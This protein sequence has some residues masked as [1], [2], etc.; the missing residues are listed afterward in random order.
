MVLRGCLREILIDRIEEIVSVGACSGVVGVP[1]SAQADAKTYGVTAGGGR[2]IIL[3][4]KDVLMIAGHTGVAAPGGESS[5]HGYGR[6]E[7]GGDLAVAHA[8]PLEVG[9]VDHTRVDYDCVADL[10]CVLLIVYVVCLLRKV[11]LTRAVG[12]CDGAHV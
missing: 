5:L 9:F 2:R 10:D 11:E 8:A 6:S 4:F 7:V 3:Q 1:I 12:G